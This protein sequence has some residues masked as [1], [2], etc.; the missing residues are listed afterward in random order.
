MIRER[1]ERGKIEKIL[2]FGHK[3]NIG[4]RPLGGARRVRPPPGS[5][6]DEDEQISY[7]MSYIVNNKS[8]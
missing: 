6:S 3:K 2:R 1:S 8:F 5:A 4:P 7:L